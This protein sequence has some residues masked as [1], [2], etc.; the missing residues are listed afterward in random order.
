[1]S[2]STASRPAKAPATRT[3]KIVI[4]LIV[5]VSLI[6]VGTIVVLSSISYYLAIPAGAYLTEDEVP[7]R[8]EDVIRSLYEAPTPSA[9]A[10]PG[11]VKRQ[12]F[13]EI[14]VG[15]GVSPS[16][17]VMGTDTIAEVWE[18]L[19][20]ELEEEF[21]QEAVDH[22]YD[23]AVEISQVS[24]PSGSEDEDWVWGVDGKGTGGYWMR[25]D[26]D[27]TVQDTA[28]WNRLY[29]V[30]TR[31]IH[32][33]WKTDSLPAKWQKAW[34]ECREGMPD[35][36]YFLWTDEVS[37]QFVA[38]HYPSFL[39]MYDS[40]KY[41]IQRADSIRYFILHH[42]GGIYMDL[43]IGCRRRMD[44]LLQGDW[45]AILPITKPV[46]VSNDLIFSSKGSAFM[47]DVVH[48]LPAFNHEWVTNYPTVMFSTGHARLRWLQPMFLSAQYAI[49]TSAHP[50]TSTHPRAEVRILPKSLYGKNAPPETVPH[51]FFSHF[52]GSSWHADD[53]GF[54]SFL[55]TW[56]TRLMYVAG[57]VVIV[58]A[59]RLVLAKAS[60][61][62]Q[63]QLIGGTHSGTTTPSESP[64]SPLDT[65]NI[66]SAFRR[67]GNLIFTAPATFL[68]RGGRRRTGLLYFVPAM[69]Q[70]NTR[71]ARTAS[72]ASQLPFRR[73]R[74]ERPPPPYERYSDE[75]VLDS[76]PLKSMPGKD[77]GTVEEVDAFLKSV[78]E[79]A[80]SSASGA[81]RL[82]ED[83]EGANDDEDREEIWAAWEADREEAARA[84]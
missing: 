43:D 53:A 25:E 9:T 30:T 17:G 3:R 70:P 68:S 13:E 51:S 26:W 37:R 58:V 54:I 65:E 81:S 2:L 72:E 74:G 71:R 1:M 69:F 6:L 80:E 73:P 52:Y 39:Q 48:G 44:G 83:K 5:L 18:E 75:T 60:S 49:Y 11:K 41:P 76:M 62:P 46:G 64:L 84:K 45:E 28:S 78:E 59:L 35:Y 7:W 10:T 82:S 31:L 55:G 56:G 57:A 40:Y 29:N 50:I 47:D 21:E 63:Y 79:E 33:T 36:E 14:G 42:F 34:R 22:A 16:T 66:S 23:D 24:S 61:R 77:E 27:G 32:Q 8:P 19:E 4:T 20:E 15:A 12:D 67:A 38:T